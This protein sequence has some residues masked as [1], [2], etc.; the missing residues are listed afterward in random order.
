MYPMIVTIIQNELTHA[1]RRSR[2]S[3]GSSGAACTRHRAWIGRYVD[4]HRGDG[5]VHLGHLPPTF[6]GPLG[7]GLLR[8]AR[9]HSRIPTLSNRLLATDLSATG[10]NTDGWLPLLYNRKE[11]NSVPMSVMLFIPSRANNELPRLQPATLLLW[12]VLILRNNCCR[13]TF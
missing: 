6:L 13:R 8:F 2:R 12:I 4:A 11:P 10:R 3:A 1:G 9:T 5:S 7:S